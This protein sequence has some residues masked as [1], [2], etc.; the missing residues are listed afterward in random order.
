MKKLMVV[1]LLITS[2]FLFSSTQVN[3]FSITYNSDYIQMET[4]ETIADEEVYLVVGEING[5]GDPDFSEIDMSRE[6]S[7][8]YIDIL[9][10]NN[11]V[12]VNYILEKQSQSYPYSWSEVES[13][14]STTQSGTVTMYT[15]I[16][17][18][19]TYRL[20]IENIPSFWNNTST[21]MQVKWRANIVVTY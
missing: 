11:S 13:I 12:K 7:K 15:T 10:K 3:A 4:G 6:Y 21:Y 2:A 8:I 1:A 5:N 19:Y 18:G 9:Y 16:Y 17:S 20:K 14:E